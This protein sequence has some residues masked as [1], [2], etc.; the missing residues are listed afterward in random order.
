MVIRQVLPTKRCKRFQGKAIRCFFEKVGIDVHVPEM[1][2]GHVT[3]RSGPRL[4]ALRNPGKV[5]ARKRGAGETERARE[6]LNRRHKERGRGQ[7]GRGLSL[8]DRP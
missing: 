5:G 3:F 1:C 4:C 6:N 8:C 7:G 2:K